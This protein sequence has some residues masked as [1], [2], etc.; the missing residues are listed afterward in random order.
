MFKQFRSSHTN[1]CPFRDKNQ[2]NIFFQ[3]LYWIAQAVMG[4]LTRNRNK[5]DKMFMQYNMNIAKQPL[6]SFSQR[7][8]A[9]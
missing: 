7:K 6:I 3:M 5:K 2:S 1:S 8:M 4:T 9:Y